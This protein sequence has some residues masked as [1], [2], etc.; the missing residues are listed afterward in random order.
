MVLRT[1]MPR[2]TEATPVLR[3]HVAC[4]RGWSTAVLRPEVPRRA[5]P[6][7][8]L[9]AVRARRPIVVR[10][11]THRPTMW[12]DGVPGRD[13]AAARKLARPRC[14]CDRRSSVVHRLPEVPVARRKML[15]VPLHRR[16]VEVTLMFR[17][18]LVCGRTR[19]Q[20]TGAA[21]EADTVHGDVVDNRP[22]VYVRHVNAADVTDRP[23][24]K[25]GPTAP[26][27][28]L[29]S[30]TGVPEAVVHTAIESDVRAPVA[31]VP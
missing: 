7:A 26:V 21:V 22:V 18:Q 16:R 5:W 14:R 25:E 10:H 23:V 17:T 2:G 12:T 24:I 28:A 29:E 1:N 15:M 4:G 31:G 20:T 13:N 6:T 11:I 30:N 9:G 8:I 27:T 3:T 19:M